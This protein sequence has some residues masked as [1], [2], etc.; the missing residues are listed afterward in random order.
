V[1]SALLGAQLSLVLVDYELASA[2]V[3]HELYWSLAEVGLLYPVLV[4][5]KENLVE[6]FSFARC[7]ARNLLLPREYIFTASKLFVV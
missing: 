7:Y 1:S 6:G 2:P 3:G 4:L 5:N